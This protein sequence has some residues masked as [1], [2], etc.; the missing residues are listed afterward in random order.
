MD[1]QLISPIALKAKVM[2]KSA[3]RTTGPNKRKKGVKKRPKVKK[4]KGKKTNKSG[5]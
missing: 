5:Y 4:G 2:G 3:A 1:T